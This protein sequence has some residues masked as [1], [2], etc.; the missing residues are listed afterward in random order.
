MS[1]TRPVAHETCDVTTSFVSG[2]TS[3]GRS[4]NGTTRTLTPRV[5][6]AVASGPSTPGCSSS[7]V[8]TLVA[9]GQVERVDGGVH[10]VG[11]GAGDRDVGL[12]GAEQ[13]RDP[14]A[15]LVDP[16]LLVVEPLAAA[17]PALEL[18]AEVALH[19]V[20]RRARD[21][22]VRA[23]VQVGDPLEDREL[24]SELLHAGRILGCG[25]P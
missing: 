3:P 13:S 1:I 14:P 23:G 11:R 15:E 18:V 4:S 16:R 25:R 8:S 6:R 12:L 5:S 21:R 2:R 24:G 20:E 7:L 10:A 17:A 22:A 19:R 9:G